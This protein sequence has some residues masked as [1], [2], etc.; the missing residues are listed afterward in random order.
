MVSLVGLALSALF[1]GLVGW[2]I[3]R[4]VADDFL[5]SQAVADQAALDF[6][7][8]SDVISTVPDVDVDDLDRFVRQSILRGDFVRAKL[9][10]LD[11]TI[12]Y[13]DAS[14]L[15]GQRFAPDEDFESLITSISE[16]SD[17]SEEEN[18]LEAEQFGAL[19][20]TYV[21]VLEGDR[22]LAV[23]E[24]YRTL[25]AYDASVDQTRRLVWITFGSGLGLLGL[26]LVSTLG[27]LVHIADEQRRSAESRADDLVTLLEVARMTTQ[28]DS[29]EGL[30]AR[31]RSILE[32]APQVEW[33]VAV[34][35]SDD[36]EPRR[37]LEVGSPARDLGEPRAQEESS[38]GL[39]TVHIESTGASSH[40]PTIDALAEEVLVGLQ[41]ALL[42]EGLDDYRRQLEHVMEQLVDAD[43]SE[44]RRLAGDVH[45]SVARDLYRILYGVRTLAA[46]APASAQPALAELEAAILEASGSLRSLLRDLYPS[47][48]EDVGLAASLAS[49][50]ERVAESYD[51]AVELDIDRCPEPSREVKL[52]VYRVAQEALVN[53]ARHS[54]SDR[55]TLAVWAAADRVEFTIS[56]H[57]AGPPIGWRA[58]MGIWLMR[59][60]VERLGGH[61]GFDAGDGLIVTGSIPMGGAS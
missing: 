29:P 39:L 3:P 37:L 45:D 25:D 55:A 21:P 41:K 22:V 42:A 32:S 9:W 61:I 33:V 59:D 47:V 11:G 44:R 60:R 6:L 2:Y 46:D 12:L 24:I 4:R 5:A 17:L 31:L 34:L 30:A 54:G 28:A 57:G 36:S 7:V 18:Y 49:L 40:D 53:A 16:V 1:A 26:F 15:I 13:S 43:D 8:S 35:Q 23:W 38:A 27:S 52:A 19:L 20:E 10:S 48:A 50:A 58:G 14:E 56:D 51:L